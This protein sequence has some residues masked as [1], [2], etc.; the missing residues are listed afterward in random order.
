MTKQAKPGH[1]C[2]GNCRWYEEKSSPCLGRGRCIWL[3]AHPGMVE[4]VPFWMMGFSTVNPIDGADCHQYR[5][6]DTA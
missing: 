4:E 1:R 5:R 2:C 6:H 3:M